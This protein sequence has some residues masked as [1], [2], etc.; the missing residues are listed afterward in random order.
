MKVFWS[1]QQVTSKGA[2]L[3][4]NAKVWQEVPQGSGEAVPPTNGTEHSWQETAAAQGT[5][6]EGEMAQP[7]FRHQLCPLLGS[8]EGS[9]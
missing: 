3:N 6:A 7:W 1:L 9:L 2:G 5:P 4:P 8:T